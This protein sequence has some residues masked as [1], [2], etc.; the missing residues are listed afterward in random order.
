MLGARSPRPVRAA[1]VFPPLPAALVQN[2]RKRIAELVAGACM[3]RFNAVGDL[4][5]LRDRN[6]VVSEPLLAEFDTL[7]P[8]L[9]RDP[10][11]GGYIGN[12]TMEEAAV[13]FMAR[14]HGLIRGSMRRDVTGIAEFVDRGDQTWDVKS[15][16]SPPV[17]AAWKLDAG[18]IVTKIRH[19]LMQGDRV[20]LNLMR[21]TSADSTAIVAVVQSGLNATERDRV[22]VLLRRPDLQAPRA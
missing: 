8:E 4:V 15:P 19:D 5:A 9:I 22:S 21:C 16:V 10:A 12:N 17:G 1:T 6:P 7:L 13:G 14:L 2:V 18:H 20:L 11:R 3:A